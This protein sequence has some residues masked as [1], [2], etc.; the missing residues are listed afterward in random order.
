MVALAKPHAHRRRAIAILGAVA[1]VI[2]VTVAVAVTRPSTHHQPKQPVAPPPSPTTIAQPQLYWR[3]ATGIGRANLNGTGIVRQ[4]IPFTAG[5]NQGSSVKNGGCGLAV[6]H[7][8]L[9]WP[10]GESLAR[11]KLDGTG[12][13]TGFIATGPG[14]NC[15]AVDG[16]HIYWTTAADATSSGTIG[17]AKL[18]G[19][20]VQRAFIAAAKAPCGLAVDGAHIY[21]TN[22]STGAVGRANVDGTGVNQ[23]FL[24]GL[25][26]GTGCGVVVDRAHIAWGAPSVTAGCL[27]C[28][29]I[30]IANLDRTGNYAYFNNP[31]G[32]SR[33]FELPCASDGTYLYWTHSF[34]GV[35]SPPG[36]WIGRAKIDGA[37]GPPARIPP[38]TLTPEEV[39][40]D[41]AAL[42]AQAAAAA[43]AADVRGDFITTGPDATVGAIT[44]CAIGPSPATTTVPQPRPVVP[45]PSPTTEPPTTAAAA[46]PRAACLQSADFGLAPS[47]GS[48]TFAN[49]QVVHIV[50]NGCEA[51]V[52]YV[53]AEC[54][55]SVG[56]PGSA[57]T[58]DCLRQSVVADA[59]G[60]V[61]TYFKIQRVFPWVNCDVAPGC[62]LNLYRLLNGAYKWW[63]IGI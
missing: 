40:A 15:V 46:P 53:V 5:V 55:N 20:G 16:S 25:G 33:S 13:D 28:F 38:T 51:G 62:S 34:N 19:T 43:A 32:P 14:T 31:P 23:D 60:T 63:G 1:A 45:P 36:A 7:N 58:G 35:G 9:Y 50:A 29:D 61:S 47:G 48:P 54:A 44:G 57:L 8:Y 59:T 21:W 3:D 27:T 17:R 2:V 42:A 4:L 30:G 24:G 56:P 12:V 26:D 41:Q 22:S 49:G 6:D 39:A 10:A 11:A 18:D 37:H 52:T